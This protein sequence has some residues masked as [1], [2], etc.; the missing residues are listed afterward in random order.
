M[1]LVPA[2]VAFTEVPA[3]SWDDGCFDRGR[4][5]PL[6]QVSIYADLP[7]IHRVRVCDHDDQEH[8]V[9]LGVI[10]ARRLFDLLTGT[11]PLSHRDVTTVMREAADTEPL[12]P[13][14]SRRWVGG[15]MS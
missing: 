2:R 10:E 14:G 12:P 7:L 15:G 11:G 5:V 4:T 9:L 13:R 3:A 8:E 6:W 1:P